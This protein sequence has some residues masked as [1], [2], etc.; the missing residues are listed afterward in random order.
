VHFTCSAVD[1]GAARWAGGV[2]GADGVI[3]LPAPWLGI[4]SLRSQ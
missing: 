3:N 1:D 4:A 2:C